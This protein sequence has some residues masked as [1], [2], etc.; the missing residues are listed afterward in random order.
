MAP[1]A[2]FPFQL[3]EIPKVSFAFTTRLGGDS[4]GPFASANLS[5]EV[6]DDPATVL[7]NRAIL[8]EQLGFESWAELKQVH[9]TDMV[10]D[11]KPIPINTRPYLEADGQ[12]TTRAGQVL[13]VKTA[14]CQP[15]LFA[16]RSGN[17]VMAIHV[18][19]RGNRD[20]FI[21]KSVK[22][23]SAKYGLQLRDI[24]AVRGPSI[25]P[26]C[27]E[28]KD[29]DEHFDKRYKNYFNRET[30]MLDLWR[31]TKNQLIGTGIPEEN[32]HFFDLCT[33]TMA[34]TFFSYRNN[35]ETGRQAGLVWIR[36]E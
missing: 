19:W 35:N 13:V 31:M 28:F 26:M 3:D 29:F 36:G 6:G 12:A 7:Q 1:I 4:E 18:G 16:H 33:K 2:I 14:D 32:C 27:M 34:D 5:L 30:Q 17:F 10:F 25:G 9:G 8:K 21:A 15:I 22:L 20:N 24:H 23:F 11:P